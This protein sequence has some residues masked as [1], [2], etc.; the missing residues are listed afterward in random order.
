MIPI[1][2]RMNGNASWASASVM[3]ILSVQ[4]PRNPASN[5]SEAPRSP[6]TT[7]AAKPTSRDT[8][9][10]KITRE[11]T[12]RPRWS[13]PSRW[14]LPSAP[15]NVG[16]ESR[17]RSDWRMGSAGAITGA[18]SAARI[19]SAT[20]TAPPTARPRVRRARLAG[21]CSARADARIEEA[22]DQVD[23]E[24]DH[25]EE[26]GGDEHG[27]LHD[28]VVAVV[29]R[30]DGEP[31]DTRPREDRLGDDGAAE[32]GTEL[33]PGDRDD[34]HRRVLQGVLDDHEHFRDAL[35]A[36]GADVVR[37]QHLEHRGAREPRDR[38]HREGAERQRGQHQALPA[39]ATRRRQQTEVERDDQD[40]E[41][42]D[43]E[44]R[45]RLADEGERHRRLIDGGVSFH[46]RDDPDGQ[47]DQQR[48]GERGE[49][50]LEGRGQI[51]ED[52]SGGRLAEMDGL[53]KIPVHDVAE[54]DRVLHG[55][56]AVQAELGA[57]AGK[58][59]LRRVGRQQERHR[60]A[61][62]PHDHEDDG[63]DEPESDRRAEEPR[64]EK[65][66]EPAHGP[67]GGA[68]RAPPRATGLR[69]AE[70]EIEATDLELLER[71]RRP[72]H[73]LLKAVVLVRL[74][75]RDP[76]EIFE[77]ELRHFLVRVGAELLV[78]RKA[79][80]AAQLVELRVPPVV[81]RTAR[82]EEPPH[83]AVGITQGRGGIRPPEPLEALL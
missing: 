56:R 63:R 60:I 1:A 34:R 14:A 55:E 5:P 57:D 67:W 3:I 12:S 79:R 46:G 17:P 73:V 19:K 8:R 83:H 81:L 29:D 62:Q 32:Q 82:T 69:A 20:N 30:L 44:G 7:T 68:S 66:K 70:L 16:A 80:G 52:H 48:Q 31:A 76:R 2:R 18:A 15:A 22:I 51:V 58:L 4:P 43:E 45:R 39:L 41:D 37:A 71:I 28:G 33:Q 27:A 40:Q 47:G 38:R 75:Y 21:A 54:E 25:D 61:R 11:R 49:A 50:E 36:G 10:P 26:H 74:D 64:G 77:K 9:A 23:A 78:D 72:L 53:A 13:V 65:G 42:P 6:P 24:V 35:G 59:A